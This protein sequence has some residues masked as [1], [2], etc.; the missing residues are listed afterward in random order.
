MNLEGIMLN[1]PSQTEKNKYYMV[2]L[3]C[4]IQKKQTQNRLVAA[5]GSKWWM[6]EMGEGGQKAQT[7]SYK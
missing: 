7:S 2:G 5:R 1:E 4:G 3:T 6:G